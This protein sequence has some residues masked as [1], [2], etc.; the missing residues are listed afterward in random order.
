MT[1]PNPLPAFGFLAVVESTEWGAVGGYLVLNTG[2]RP[3]EFHCTA[4]VKPSRSQEILYGNTLKPY[5]FGEQIAAALVAKAK[6]PALLLFTDSPAVMSL[7]DS[8]D[9]PLLLLDGTGSARTE[10]SRWYPTQLDKFET[11][12]EPRFA[13]DESHIQQLW[14]LHGH[15]L[16]IAEPFARVRNALEEAQK[17]ARPNAA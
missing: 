12:L 2:G 3:L 10:S 11:Y 9:T 13:K 15:T 16:D 4:P 6:V 5:L 1:Q 8:I 14:Q 17:S 7:R